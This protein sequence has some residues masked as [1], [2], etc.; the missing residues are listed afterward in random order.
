METNWINVKVKQKVDAA[1]GIVAFTLVPAEGGDLPPF[2]AGAH[3]DVELPN[4]LVRQYSLCG[5]PGA[6][7]AYEL[8][9]LLE[10]G[11]RGGSRSAH[12]DVEEGSALRI[13]APRNLFPLQPTGR[14]VLLAGGI[15][16]TP[17]LA[18][19]EALSA[20]GRDFEF[21]YCCRSPK[22]AAFLERIKDS[23]YA[24]KVSVH[25]DDG[26][27]AQKLNVKDVLGDPGPDTHVYFCGPEGFIDF[28]LKSTTDLGWNTA[29]VHLERFD[30]V[31]VIEEGD[32]AFDVEIASSGQLIQVA[33]DQTVLD[34][35]VSAGVDV[36][37]SCEQGICGTCV[38]KVIEGEPDH[39]DMFFTDEEHAANDQF[40]PCCSRAKT[41]RLVID[42]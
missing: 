13:S 26:D 32:M 24:D 31:P 25:F 4:G 28:I 22:R 23:A 21:H 33:A 29:N 17:I 19:A 5:S 6:T 3:V 35:L 14:S 41:K 40:T 10:E 1:D 34:A 36:P 11:G 9:I 7:A 8:G 18:M 27:D 39:R 42:F 16:V 12:E 37:V 2:E 15:G 30:A 20:A 38:M